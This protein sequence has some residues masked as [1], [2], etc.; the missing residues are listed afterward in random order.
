VIAVEGTQDITDKKLAEQSLIRN[1][2]LDE[3]Q[4]IAKIAGNLI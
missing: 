4:S 1:N 2:L 3:S